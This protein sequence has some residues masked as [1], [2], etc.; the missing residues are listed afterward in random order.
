[1]RRRLAAVLLPVAAVSF[2]SLPR[3]TLARRVRDAVAAVELE[4]P[5]PKQP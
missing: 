4:R 1:M 5:P 2:A 3:S